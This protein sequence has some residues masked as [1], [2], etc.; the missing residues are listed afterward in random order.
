MAIRGS[1]D[2]LARLGG[3]DFGLLAPN[4]DSVG[5]GRLTRRLGEVLP[6]GVVVSIGVTTWDGT[7]NGSDLWRCADRAMYETKL[8]HRRG[9]MR[10]Q[11]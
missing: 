8:R 10:L 3:D 9:D 5:I 2:F 7:E 4:S 11:A 6:S 1:G